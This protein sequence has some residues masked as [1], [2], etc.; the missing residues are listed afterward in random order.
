MFITK[1]FLRAQQGDII[2]LATD[3]Y[4]IQKDNDCLN[5]FNDSTGRIAQ[6]ILIR[7]GEPDLFKKGWKN[8]KDAERYI[9]DYDSALVKPLKTYPIC[10]D[11]LPFNKVFHS[12]LPRAKH[13]AQLLFPSGVEL[14]EDNRFIEHHRKIMKFANVKLPHGF[15]IGGSRIL[16]FLGLNDKGIESSKEAKR[17]TRE[18]AVILADEALKHEY[19]VL[20]AHGL[21]NRYLKKYLKKQD[22]KHIRKEGT[23]YWSIN[24]L[25][26]QIP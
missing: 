23:N 8:R 17:R 26:K 15:W 10:D 6:I 4:N 11:K 22:W 12:S 24:I 1:S 2:E 13:T 19:A 3:Y 5:F 14:Q 9:Q 16:W 18:N 21:H 20:V 7:H 25:A